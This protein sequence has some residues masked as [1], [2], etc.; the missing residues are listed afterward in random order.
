MK[1]LTVLAILAM[2]LATS[3]SAETI[4][5]S[6]LLQYDGCTGGCGT[7][8]FGS[9]TLEKSAP[10]VVD[11]TVDLSPDS[12]TFVNTGLKATFAFNLTGIPTATISTLDT[13]WSPAGPGAFQM[14]AF[15]F[16]DYAMTWDKSGG[17]NGTLGPLSFTVSATGLTVDSFRDY[18]W[19][20]DPTKVNGGA[21]SPTTYLFAADIMGSTGNTGAVGGGCEI[22][23]DADC[24]PPQVPEPAS[25][26]LL[27]TGLIGAGAFARK[28]RKQ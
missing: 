14:S 19:D 23:V 13:G 1:R 3:A 26:L 27:G 18:S 12:M 21:P 8:P 20:K 11:V 28:R 25:M 9:V 10:G 6:F 4:T 22:G 2:A 16:F 7:P 17:G 5:T 15:G 24:N